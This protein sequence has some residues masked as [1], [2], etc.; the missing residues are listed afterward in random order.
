MSKTIK[1]TIAYDGTGYS[2]WQKQK[3]GITVQET[4][5]KALSVIVNTPI[6]LHGAGRTDTGVHALGMTA[7][8]HTTKT[9]APHVFLKGLNSMLPKDIR[10]I[11]SCE[12]ANDFHARFSAFGK[13]YSYHLFTGAIQLPHQRLYAAHIPQKLDTNNMIASLEMLKGKHDFSSFETSGSRDKTITTGKGAIRTIYTADLKKEG[14]HIIITFCGDGFLRHM[15]RNIVGTLLEVGRGKRTT[16]N[17]RETLEAKDRARG[18]STAAAKGLFLNQ[19][20]YSP[21]PPNGS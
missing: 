3:N 7:H 21:P 13:I 16:Q 10:I 18:G 8:F 20:L 2:G 6:S 17:F 9:H 4:I 15:V 14:D 19:V 1:L 5:E 11:E 12:K